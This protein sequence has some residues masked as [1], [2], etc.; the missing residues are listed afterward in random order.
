MRNCVKN[1]NGSQNP[2]MKVNASSLPS[3]DLST[4]LVLG[5]VVFCESCLPL[6]QTLNLFYYL[7]PC[8]KFR[9]RKSFSTSYT[10]DLTTNTNIIDNNWP[11]YMKLG[12]SIHIIVRIH[13]LT[14]FTFLWLTV[15]IRPPCEHM[16]WSSISV[17]SSV[18]WQSIKMTYFQNSRFTKMKNNNIGTAPTI[19]M[20][21]WKMKTQYNWLRY[22]NGNILRRNVLVTKVAAIF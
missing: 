7:P 3:I 14:H 20:P 11:I 21:G 2:L 22:L 18:W 13:I 6:R 5:S 16:R 12:I 8:L 19:L 10:H 9:S 4:Y 15:S 1:Y 17:W